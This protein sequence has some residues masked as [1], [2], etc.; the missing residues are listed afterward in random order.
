MGDEEFEFIE[1]MVE[2]LEETIKKLNQ[3]EARIMSKLDAVRIRELKAFWLQEM[4][5]DDALE[6]KST[7]DY[8]DKMM[9][10]IWSRLRRAHSTRA[11]AGQAIMKQKLNRN[12]F[13]KH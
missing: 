7:F 13:D 3:E 11:L 8:W 12:F 6:F 1:E 4:E 5:E 10:F 9:I 2:Q